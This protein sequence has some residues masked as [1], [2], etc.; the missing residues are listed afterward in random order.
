MGA[1]GRPENVR[2][3]LSNVRLALVLA[4]VALLIY[5]GFVVN[6]MTSA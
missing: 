1:E 5:L 2:V 3:R 6:G 4:G